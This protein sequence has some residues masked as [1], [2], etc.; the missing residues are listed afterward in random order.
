MNSD[1]KILT[2]VLAIRLQRVISKLV[3]DNQS[4]FIKGRNIAQ[5]LREIDDL[6]EFEKNRG[7]S[8]I[9]LSVDFEKAFDTISST[10]IVEMCRAY[11]LGNNFMNWI[12]IIMNRRSACVKN[13][14]FISNEFPLSRG[15]RQGCPLSPLLFV[16][17]VEL[18]AI[19]TRQDTSIE[20]CKVVDS[21]TKIRQYAD[22]TTF[23]VKNISEA[24]KVLNILND[25]ASF[26]GLK[27]NKIKS[28]AFCP[29][30][31]NHYGPEVHGIKFVEELELLGV[32]FSIHQIASKVMKNWDSKMLKT[33]KMIKNWARRDLTII[34][35]IL[36]LKTFGISN[37]VYLMQ[38]IGM[39]PEVA[40]KLNTLFFKFIWKS[41]YFD[42]GKTTE[43]VKR[44]VLFNDIS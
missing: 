34:G 24:E 18:I 20:G 19:K 10:F 43:K 29:G 42:A 7:S 17:A 27:V 21:F 35:K 14:G 2:K 15:I 37:F 44:R 23:L 38:S 40:T 28:K 30:S 25:F 4:G 33:E 39:P 3:N 32:T 1:Y 11:G 5:V 22:D 12:E 31:P 16:L 13:N 36:V 6:V 8:N 9:F 26:S 41:N